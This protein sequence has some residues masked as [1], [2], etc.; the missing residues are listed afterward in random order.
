M[1][2]GATSY[3][4]EK[5]SVVSPYDHPASYAA[6]FAFMMSGFL[7]NFERRNSKVPSDGRL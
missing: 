2:A 6:M 4:T 5:A 7:A 1:L 3:C